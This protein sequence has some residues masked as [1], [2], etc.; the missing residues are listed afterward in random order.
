M[1]DTQSYEVA[2]ILKSRSQ[3]LLQFDMITGN[4]KTFGVE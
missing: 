2:A 3:S 1:T 4:N